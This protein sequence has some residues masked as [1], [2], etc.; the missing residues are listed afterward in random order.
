[1]S[2]PAA[3]DEYLSHLEARNYSPNTICRLRTV[4]GAFARFCDPLEATEADVE[5][6]LATRRLGPNARYTYLQYVGGFYR[7]AI[8][9][10]HCIADP[11]AEIERPKLGYRLPR[12]IP[13]AALAAALAAADNRMRLWL[14]LAAFQGM[15]CQEIAGLCAEHV[16]PTNPPMLIIAEGKGRRERTATMNVHTEAALAAFG[17][18]RSGPL[19]HRGCGC[20]IRPQTVTIYV[21][22]YLHGL[23][24]DYTAHQLRHWFGTNLYRGTL[25]IRATQAAL[26]HAS[27]VT[28]QT[29]TAFAPGAGS[30]VIRFMHVGPAA[31]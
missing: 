10:G 7:W 2:V 16:L 22:R 19:F 27:V 3:L 11:T 28:T 17:L 30:E 5:A 20:A 13:D 24:L 21:S 4:V 6:W 8:R 31:A 18:P 15:R 26:G 23:G 25:D 14:C 12:P 9:K 1:M 29:Y